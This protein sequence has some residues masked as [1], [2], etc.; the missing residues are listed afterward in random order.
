MRF[1]YFTLSNTTFCRI[2]SIKHFFIVPPLRAK[3]SHVELALY[4]YI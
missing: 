1:T 2:V 3:D 4:L